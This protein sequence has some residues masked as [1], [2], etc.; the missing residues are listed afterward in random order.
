LKKIDKKMIGRYND[1][2][3][4]K[5]ENSNNNNMSDFMSGYLRA[6]VEC[7]KASNVLYNKM[8]VLSDLSEIV[9]FAEKEPEAH[10]FRVEF[11]QPI[12]RI[13]DDNERQIITHLSISYPSDIWGNRQHDQAPDTIETALF[14]YGK[15][16]YVSSLDYSDIRR[17]DSMDEVVEEIRR[18]VND[19]NEDVE[20]DEENEEESVR[21]NRPVPRS[22]EAVPLIREAIL[23]YSRQLDVST[24]AVRNSINVRTLRIEPAYVYVSLTDGVNHLR[25][26]FNADDAMTSGGR[27][28]ESKNG[29][30]YYRTY[31][32]LIEAI[33][34]G[35]EES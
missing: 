31:G 30:N 13:D 28:V 18:I 24:I 16:I 20:K 3:N 10:C 4:Q 14:S 11:C 19:V 21:N 23:H 9:R 29:P 22:I 33:Q 35:L 5:D 7:R 32:E 8:K 26:W 15:L 27:V 25:I 2:N 1:F 34:W 12:R 17:F 6:M